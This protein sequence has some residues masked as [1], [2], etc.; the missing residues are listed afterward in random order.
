MVSQDIGPKGIVGHA[1]VVKTSV[2]GAVGVNELVEVVEHAVVVILLDKK[3]SISRS[4]VC[5][6]SLV[7]LVG[8]NWCIS[9]PCSLCNVQDFAHLLQN[10]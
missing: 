7:V 1:N 10:G 4:K 3:L 8:Q 5:K 9:L 6:R 2:K